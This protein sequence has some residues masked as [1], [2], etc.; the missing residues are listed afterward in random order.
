[1]PVLTPDQRTFLAAARTATLATVSSQGRPRLVPVCF[2]LGEDDE[3]GRTVLYS[4]LDEKPKRTADVRDLARVRDILV[5][6]EVTL[7]VDRWDEDWSRLAWLRLYGTGE[8]LEPQPHEVEEHTAAIVLL[9][10]K[11]SQYARHALE[12]LPIICIRLD[13]AIG[14]TADPRAEAAPD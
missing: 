9:R 12:S 3:R 4:P 7:L 2:A 6:P 14:W 1:M 11:Y 13:R 8:L 10:A 5:L